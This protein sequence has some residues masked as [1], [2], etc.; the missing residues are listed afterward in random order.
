MKA[1]VLREFG[2]PE[3]LRYE[4]VA[5]PTPAPDEVL[6]QVHA[7]SVNRTL[8]LK[9]RQGN[10]DADVTLP[11]VL[12]VDPSGVVAEAGE[13]VAGLEKGDRVGVISML[14]CG[15]CRY[16]LSGDDGDCRETRHIGVH[17]WGGYAEYVSVPAA[18][19]HL[20]PEQ[21][22]FPEATVIM[23]HVPAA[24]NLIEK[25]ELQADEWVLVM[26]AAGALGSCLVQV[27]KLLGAHVIAGAGSDERVEAARS[28]G[29]EYGVNYRRQDLAAEV[30]RM[31]DGRGVGV[32]FENIA[33]P[34]LWPGAFK[35]LGFHG[36]LVTAGAHGGGTVALDVNQLYR[37]RQKIIGAAGGSL[38]HVARTLEAARTGSLRGFVH[39]VMPLRE[40]A[41]AHRLLEE[42]SPLGKII[43]D[44]T[45]G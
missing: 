33:D 2:E 19:A 12:G 5:T 23:R 22:P 44:P 8:D 24:F 41:A 7:V 4:E 15:T 6:L 39:R 42:S 29:A 30:S 43:L 28:Y 17:R 37:R 3:I 45:L 20:L 10:Y 35:S 32:V 18:N 38:G 21:L 36:R 13:R 1:I 14:R 31:T 9:V 34:T 26:G 25:A 16:C 27:A 11:L 40:A